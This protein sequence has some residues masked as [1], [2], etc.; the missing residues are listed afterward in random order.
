LFLNCPKFLP[1]VSQFPFR[2]FAVA[3]EVPPLGFPP[4]NY[5]F[6]NVAFLRASPVFLFSP[7]GVFYT[8]P[9]LPRV[10]FFPT[11]LRHPC[12]PVL[13]FPRST[14]V[15]TSSLSITL[16]SIVCRGGLFPCRT[17]DNWVFPFPLYFSCSVIFVPA[18]FFFFLLDLY[19]RSL[20][21][22]SSHGPTF[23]PLWC[24]K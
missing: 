13:P 15:F 2:G 7:R 24:S 19:P 20:F 17:C 11:L 21:K 6:E 1:F 12:G 18:S 22:P 4:A 3:N 16:H 14:V 5:V 8:F 23:P 10:F 9:T